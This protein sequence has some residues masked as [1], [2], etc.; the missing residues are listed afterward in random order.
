MQLTSQALPGL[1][2]GSVALLLS[3]RPRMAPAAEAEAGG[4]HTAGREG[5]AGAPV[6]PRQEAPSSEACRQEGEFGTAKTPEA[7][8]AD[9]RVVQCS[10]QGQERALWPPL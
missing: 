6:Y 2:P 1:P 4:A 9:P 5:A 3:L 8:V 10:R 7:A